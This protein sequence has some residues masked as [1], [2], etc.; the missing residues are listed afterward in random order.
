MTLKDQDFKE[1]LA[2]LPKLSDEQ[3]ERVLT[4]LKGSQKLF[5]SIARVRDDS[6]KDSDWLLPGICAALKMKGLLSAQ[7]ER[8]IKYTKGYERYAKNAVHLMNDLDR[9]LPRTISKSQG[10]AAI[11]QLAGI[12]L[13]KWCQTCF[14]LDKPLSAS[15]VLSNADK[16]FESIE[17]CFPGYVEANML[18]VVIG[19]NISG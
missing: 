13:I 18:H 17:L 1:L 6:A 8:S 14:K 11:A 2:K 5:G 16:T 4:N 3:R 7:S 9:L 19:G 12:A 15:F 10:R